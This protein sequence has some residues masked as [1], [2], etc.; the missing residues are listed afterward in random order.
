VITERVP[1]IHARERIDVA[2]LGNGFWRVAGRYGFME[3]PN[4][5]ALLR[6]AEPHGLTL[7]PTETTYYLSR[8]TVV[9]SRKP[10]MASWREHLFGFMHRNATPISAFFGLRPNRVVELGTQLEI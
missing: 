5:P 7:T 1:Y 8:E 3:H 10:G 2:S 4:V 9:P 6:L